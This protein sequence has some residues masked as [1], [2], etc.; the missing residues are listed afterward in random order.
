MLPM[1][2]TDPTGA[3][4]RLAVN[5]TKAA[6]LLDMSVDSFERSVKPSLPTVFAGRKLYR[7]KD[8]ERWL[9]EATT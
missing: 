1:S 7:V 6:A 3:E 4:R 9:A 2:R 5:Q 8:L